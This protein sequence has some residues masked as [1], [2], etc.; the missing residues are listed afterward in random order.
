MRINSESQSQSSATRQTNHARPH[1][2]CARRWR[3]AEPTLPAAPA[4]RSRRRRAM[5]RRRWARRAAYRANPPPPRQRWRARRW[6]GGRGA[7]GAAKWTDSFIH[8]FVAEASVGRGR[9][10]EVDGIVTRVRRATAARPSRIA[11]SSATCCD[12]AS[13]TP[14]RCVPSTAAS[15]RARV[16]CSRV[17]ASPRAAG[18][19]SACASSSRN[20][21]DS[22]NIAADAGR[23]R[24]A[25]SD[26]TPTRA[27]DS[28]G[29]SAG[30]TPRAHSEASS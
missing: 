7:W 11:R 5:R 15:A 1:A 14:S 17:C 8:S 6:L 27:I 12:R 21:A 26:P 19:S 16:C 25:V 13:G 29:R 3:R 22:R 10:G 23:G 2:A 28:A 24:F 9:A 30:R 18:K 20:P 4:P